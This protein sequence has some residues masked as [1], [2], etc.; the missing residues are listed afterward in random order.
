MGILLSFLSTGDSFVAIIWWAGDIEVLCSVLSF[1]SL[2]H[3]LITHIHTLPYT[4]RTTSTEV[5]ERAS[6][7]LPPSFIE[8]QRHE[9]KNVKRSR[10][11]CKTLIDNRQPLNH[12]IQGKKSGEMDFRLCSQQE[13]HVAHISRLRSERR[14]HRWG[15]RY[16]EKKEPKTC[17]VSCQTND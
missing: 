16:K 5:C 12:L 13:F 14:S 7:S 3:G 9:E 15:G 1:L 8:I 6:S 10:E 17:P 2:L 11:R 4:I